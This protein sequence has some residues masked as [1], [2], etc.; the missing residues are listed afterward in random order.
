MGAQC[1]VDLEEALDL[2]DNLVEVTG[3]VAIGCGESVAVHRIGL[4]NNLVS[5]CLNSLDNTRKYGANLVVAHASNDGQTARLEV[6]IELVSV[7]NSLFRGD[8]RTNLDADW[9]RDHG[10]EVHM[11]IIHATG[12]LADPQ[13]VS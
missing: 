6:R 7:C 2:I 4:P 5:G 11:E 9:V 3:L 12:A 13:L 10:C 8:T 1:A